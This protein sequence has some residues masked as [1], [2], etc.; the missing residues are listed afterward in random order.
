MQYVEY[1]TKELILQ[2]IKKIR[3]TNYVF[4]L[5]ESGSM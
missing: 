3:P 4:A 5:D 1:S 2:T